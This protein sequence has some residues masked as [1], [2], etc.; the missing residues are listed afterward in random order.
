MTKYSDQDSPWQPEHQK[1]GV[2]AL[3]DAGFVKKLR[4]LFEATYL[5]TESFANRIGCT[6]ADLKNWLNGTGLPPPSDRE[7]ILQRAKETY[8]AACT[9]IR[10]IR[11]NL[12]W[13]EKRR[14]SYE[15]TYLCVAMYSDA[16][17]CDRATKQNT[18]EA[19]ENLFRGKQ[20]EN[21]SHRFSWEALQ[22]LAGALIVYCDRYKNLPAF[23]GSRLRKWRKSRNYTLKQLAAKV[24]EAIASEQYLCERELGILPRGV[25][26]MYLVE[27]E[28]GTHKIIPAEIWSAI[29]SREPRPV[30]DPGAGDADKRQEVGKKLLEYLKAVEDS[31]FIE[32]I[33]Q[34]E[35]D[36][37]ETFKRAIDI[38]LRYEETR[39][40]NPHARCVNLTIRQLIEI[41]FILPHQ[42]N[43]TGAI[44]ALAGLLVCAKS[45]V[46][47]S[48]AIK[49]M[50][51][52]TKQQQAERYRAR[53]QSCEL[54][55]RDES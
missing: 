23:S 35:P 55:R 15:W 44:E 30:A 41:E 17:L 9:L 2:S 42:L 48:S 10:Q 51:E 22:N 32:A 50:R 6:E 28:N 27:L 16:N 53:A 46:S 37:E 1:F 31:E 24:K 29:L 14:F 25:S 45:A 36:A 8:A 43:Q 21:D 54:P 47:Q 13:L 3:S 33:W 12:R 11:E 4:E 34:R 40:T 38:L 7:R 20:P 52:A 39:Q 19:I 18:L 5:K 26:L 49:G